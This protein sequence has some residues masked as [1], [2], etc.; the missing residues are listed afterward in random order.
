MKLKLLGLRGLCPGNTLLG[1]GLV[2][3]DPG[4]PPT[5]AALQTKQPTSSQ[6]KIHTF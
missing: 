1:S 4:P 5:Q 3:G 2:T 6:F